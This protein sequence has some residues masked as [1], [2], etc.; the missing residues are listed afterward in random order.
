MKLFE[1]IEEQLL[2]YKKSNALTKL[3]NFEK[4]FVSSHSLDSQLKWINRQ[5]QEQLN[6]IAICEREIY[7]NEQISALEK[8]AKGSPLS[9]EQT[10]QLKRHEEELRNL[11]MEWW[12][13]KRTMSRNMVDQPKGPAKEGDAV[14]LTVDVARLPEFVL[15]GHW[16]FI[17][18][19]F[20]VDAVFVEGDV[21]KF[22]KSS[23]ILIAYAK[24]H[25]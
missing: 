24:G 18:R 16:K 7:L 1:R 4:R 3:L 21:R 20:T 25:R 2:L 13:H 9:D 19:L 23:Q 12:L 10:Q 11:D 15:E 5:F 14:T 8:Q 6:G 17:A 22:Q